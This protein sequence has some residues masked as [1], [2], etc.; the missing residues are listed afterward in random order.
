MCEMKDLDGSN[1]PLSANES[2]S[3][4]ILRSAGRNSARLRF[5]QM[6]DGT[7]ERHL[8]VVCGQYAADFSVGE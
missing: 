1:P 4:G 3:L 5:I 7:G 2:S 6:F 8:P